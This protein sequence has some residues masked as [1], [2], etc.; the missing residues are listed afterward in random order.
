MDLN[1]SF[2]YKKKKK[3]SKLFESCIPQKYH[4]KPKDAFWAQEEEEEE[5]AKGS[6]ALG[7]PS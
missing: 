6:E 3:H 4:L 1:L 5:L 7:R 2:V